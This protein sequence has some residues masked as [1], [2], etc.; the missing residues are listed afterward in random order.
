MDAALCTMQIYSRE[1]CAAAGTRAAGAARPVDCIVFCFKQSITT[2]GTGA[3]DGS[4][5]AGATESI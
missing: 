4:L 5:S 3:P 1:F 2:L